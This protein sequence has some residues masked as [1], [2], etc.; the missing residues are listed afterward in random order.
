M[1]INQ[2]LDFSWFNW[3][4]LLQQYVGLS[5]AVSLFNHVMLQREVRIFYHHAED[6]ANG[7]DPDDVKKRFIDDPLLTTLC[8]L[9]VGDVAY[10]VYSGALVYLGLDN[11][12]GDGS[13]TAKGYAIFHT[14]IAMLII[15]AMYHVSGKF[16]RVGLNKGIDLLDIYLFIP[17]KM[18]FLFIL[19]MFFP[20]WLSLSVKA[21]MA[22]DQLKSYHYVRELNIF[23]ALFIELIYSGITANIMPVVTSYDKIFDTNTASNRAFCF[24]KFSIYKSDT[25]GRHNDAKSRVLAEIKL[26]EEDRADDVVLDRITRRYMN[27]DDLESAREIRDRLKTL[28]EH[29]NQ[30]D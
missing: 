28:K 17:V 2:L 29:L 20:R 12:I 30:E 15:M 8:A 23:Y 1:D 19:S 27:L 3:K 6:I 22:M 25:L 4:L 24:L 21:D 26:L 13:E 14:I 16:H 9:V 10:V 18:I 11:T 5:L 7:R